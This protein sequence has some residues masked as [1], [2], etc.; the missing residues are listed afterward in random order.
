MKRKYDYIFFDD[1]TKERILHWFKIETDYT[2]Q[3]DEVKSFIFYTKN[4]VYLYY[5]GD[6][7]DGFYQVYQ[8][9]DRPFTPTGR[10]FIIK[11]NH[12][13]QLKD[14]VHKLDVRDRSL[15]YDIDNFDRFEI[16]VNA[17]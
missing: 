7:E 3:K 6:W 11:R 2:D 16:I 13:Y 15:W 8:P 4:N 1:N 12:L 10:P 14:G 5:E 17:E 9:G